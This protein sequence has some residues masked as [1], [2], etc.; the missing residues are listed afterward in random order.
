MNRS[1]DDNNGG[2]SSF[3]ATVAVDDKYCSFVATARTTQTSYSVGEIL[4]QSLRAASALNGSGP[5]AKRLGRSQ[6]SRSGGA[7][8][9]GDR[10][11]GL[12]IDPVLLFQDARRKGAGVVPGEN[13][14]ARPGQDRPG[15]ELGRNEVNRAAVFDEPLGER[16]LV[17]VEAAQVRQQRGMNVE[18]ASPPS[19]DEGGAQHAHE[20]GEADDFD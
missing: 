6:A 14:D 11:K 16:A 3:V 8:R 7:Q 9:A 4:I 12:R 10:V 1:G 19:L 5:T 15:V 18:Q 20:P 2:V 17:G 13:R